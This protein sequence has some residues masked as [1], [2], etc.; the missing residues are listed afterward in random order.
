M[1]ASRGMRTTWHRFCVLRAPVL[2]VSADPAGVVDV[3]TSVIGASCVTRQR[4]S[5]YCE[6][7]AVETATEVAAPRH[8]KRTSYACC[9]EFGVLGDCSQWTTTET[10]YAFC[11]GVGTVCIRREPPVNFST[12]SVACI[13]TTAIPRPMHRI[14][15]ELEFR[16]LHFQVARAVHLLLTSQERALR[17]LYRVV[18]GDGVGF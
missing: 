5:R 6:P 10:S 2:K 1:L 15:S 14:S 11:C 8:C 7:R 3:K 12:V 4:L 18:V 13:S 9:C 17:F 16:P